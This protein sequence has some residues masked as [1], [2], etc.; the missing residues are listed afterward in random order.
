MI[1]GESQAI[2]VNASDAEERLNALK[3]KLKLFK[4]S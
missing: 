2:R 4:V 1:N 3:S